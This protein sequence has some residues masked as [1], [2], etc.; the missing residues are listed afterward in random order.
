MSAEA[1]AV[2]LT[3][4]GGNVAIGEAAT[5][6]ALN[7][8]A[9]TAAKNISVTATCYQGGYCGAVDEKKIKYYLQ[10]GTLKF[11]TD[12]TNFAMANYAA[13]AVPWRGLTYSA[14]DLSSNV[15]SISDYAFAKVDNDGKFVA[16]TSLETVNIPPNITSIGTKA[17]I[18]SPTMCS[19]SAAEPPFPAI[20]NLPPFS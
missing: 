7:N 11:I 4:K 14:I 2:T 15:T 10:D 17:F 1:G 3:S 16:N 9:L 18:N 6:T 13:N 19:E 8:V 12:G 5:T 20:N